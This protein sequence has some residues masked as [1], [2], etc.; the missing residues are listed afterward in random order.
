ML[1]QLGNLVGKRFGIRRKLS[2][3]TIAPCGGLYLT[4]LGV[5]AT[6]R[7]NQDYG[8]WYNQ[9][10]MSVIADCVRELVAALPENLQQ[11]ILEYVSQLSQ[12][13]PRGIPVDDFQAIAGL[14]SDED[15]E[16]ILS[17]I[18]HDCE[19]ICPNEW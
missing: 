8:A 13:A 19:Q 15:A 4:R 17:A 9:I 14:L 7:R 6:R 2:H 12:T 18:E 11:Q 10:A 16:A 3:R 5:Q 1:G